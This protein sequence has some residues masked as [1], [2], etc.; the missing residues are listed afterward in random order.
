[1]DVEAAAQLPRWA[2]L[3][4]LL[5]PARAAGQR[6]KTLK[7]SLGYSAADFSLLLG[8]TPLNIFRWGA[9]DHTPRYESVEAW[10]HA[11]F[12]GVGSG[13]VAFKDSPL[14]RH[15][16]VM[17]PRVRESVR[18]AHLFAL[19]EGMTPED[20][21]QLLTRLIGVLEA[22]DAGTDEGGDVAAGGQAAVVPPG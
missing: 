16:E 13:K 9:G 8:C 17:P 22:L 10:E 21:R 2:I 1:M 18:Q 7:A 11:E 14:G 15:I 3:M 20:R 5:D 12:L 19:L 6:L 4:G